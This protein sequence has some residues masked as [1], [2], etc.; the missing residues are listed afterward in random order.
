MS[1]NIEKVSQSRKTQY[2]HTKYIVTVCQEELY[3]HNLY[4]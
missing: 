4:I 3:L 2:V 1:A